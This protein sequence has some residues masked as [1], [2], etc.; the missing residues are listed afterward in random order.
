VLAEAAG[1]KGARD[2][3]A[4]IVGVERRIKA[5]PHTVDPPHRVVFT[6]GWQDHG[7]PVPPGSST[8]EITLVA[9]GPDGTLLR[10]VTPRASAAAL[11]MHRDGWEHYLGRL[12]IRATGG[13]PDPTAR[14]PLKARVVPNTPRPGDRPDRDT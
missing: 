10:L 2:V 8:V 6:W 3:S 7:F 5:S 1:W 13:D 4:D 14:R 9:D 11:D 12:T